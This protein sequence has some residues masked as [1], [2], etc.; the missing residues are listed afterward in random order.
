M[1]TMAGGFVRNRLLL[2]VLI[3]HMGEFYGNDGYVVKCGKCIFLGCHA[4]KLP[5]CFK[6]YHLKKYIN[7]C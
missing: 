4:Y 3:I 2:Q 5:K 7:L 6:A 1:K